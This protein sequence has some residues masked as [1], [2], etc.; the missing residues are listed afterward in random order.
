MLA[1]CK[2]ALLYTQVNML[3][4]AVQMQHDGRGVI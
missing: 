3:D 1:L 4:L 2:K